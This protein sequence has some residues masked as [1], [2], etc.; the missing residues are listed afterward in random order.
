M[1]PEVQ[2][3]HYGQCG[4]VFDFETKLYLWSFRSSRCLAGTTG[5][6]KTWNGINRN[7]IQLT[8]SPA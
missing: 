3:L 2:A 6:F 7:I 4:S 1:V 5:L 8:A